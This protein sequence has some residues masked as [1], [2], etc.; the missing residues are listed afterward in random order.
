MDE[1]LRVYGYDNLFIS[2]ASVFP[3]SVGVNPQIT[4]M[5]FADYAVPFVADTIESGGVKIITSELTKV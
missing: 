1:Q 2:D 4:V 3:T 5:A